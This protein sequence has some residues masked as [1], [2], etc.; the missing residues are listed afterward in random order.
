[1]NPS[2]RRSFEFRNIGVLQTLANRSF[3]VDLR[4][5]THKTLRLC[6]DVRVRAMVTEHMPL[7]AK[8]C[9]ITK[10]DTVAFTDRAGTMQRRS[11]IKTHFQHLACVTLRADRREGPALPLTELFCARGLWEEHAGQWALV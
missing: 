1:M 8:N 2:E 9:K 10:H 4:F 7:L 5:D 11:W 3:R 6:L